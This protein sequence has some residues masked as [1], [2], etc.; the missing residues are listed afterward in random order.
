MLVLELADF[1][2]TREMGPILALGIVVM[3]AGR[4]DAAA[5]AAVALGRRAFW[6]AIPRV[7]ARAAAAPAPLWRAR[8]APG[9]PPPAR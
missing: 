4:A 2:A 5:G 1:N 3:V 8:R 9:R 6:P 7:E